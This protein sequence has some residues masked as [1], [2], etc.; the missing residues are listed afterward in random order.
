MPVLKGLN[1]RIDAGD[2]VAAQWSGTSGAGKSTVASLL[3][4]FHEPNSGSFQVGETP[5]ENW[6]SVGTGNAWRLCHRK[7]FCSVET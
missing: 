5:A 3:L 4:R 1:L 7:S 6:T 2:Q